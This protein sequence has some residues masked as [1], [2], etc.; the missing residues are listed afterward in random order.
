MDYGRQ[1]TRMSSFSVTYSGGLRQMLF[2]F[3]RKDSV[4]MWGILT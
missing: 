3:I 4:L 2:T 1:D